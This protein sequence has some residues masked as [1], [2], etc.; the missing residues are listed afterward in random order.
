LRRAR[1][2]HQLEG[3]Q[4]PYQSGQVEFYTIEVEGWAIIQVAK[5]IAS[6]SSLGAIFF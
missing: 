2:L 6:S 3:M 1:N 5:K 4:F